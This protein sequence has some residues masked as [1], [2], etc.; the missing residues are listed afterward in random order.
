MDKGFLVLVVNV[1][2]TTFKF[3]L[4]DMKESV[5]LAKGRFERVG[6]EDSS[7]EYEGREAIIGGIL[8]TLGGYIPC[9]NMM[10]SLLIEES[11]IEAAE[12]IDAIG[13]KAVMC[14]KNTRPTVVD[15]EILSQMN[16]YS[17]VAPAHN[18]PYIA[19]MKAFREMLPEVPQVAVFDTAFHSTIPDYASVYSLRKDLCDKHDIRKYGFH[20][21]SHSYVAWKLSQVYENAS[22]IISCHLGGSASICAIKDG[23]SVDTSMGFSPQSGLPMNNRN[24]DVDAFALLYLMEK[25]DMSPKAMRELLSCECGLLG[26]SGVSGDMRDL[27]ISDKP[28]ANLAI[29]SFAYS[30]KK[31]I[32]S[33]LAVLGG[34]DIISFSGGIG[35][36]S[37][38]IRTL[39]L[40]GL[41]NFGVKLDPKKNEVRTPSELT[42]ISASDSA[43][44]VVVTPSNEELMVA[45]KTY[46]TVREKQI[47]S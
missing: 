29:K 2:S 17:F 47:S 1:G 21:A 28:E 11:V 36:N 33:Y 12:D 10:F 24:G 32:G 25:E 9:I 20:G 15:D 26:I 7:Y 4:F 41:E 22:K 14:G 37:K 43:V 30:V 3:R 16:S 23:R 34:V 31:Y 42:E 5:T 40:D 38:Y 39:A 18:P 46:D 35:E 27:E 19:A 8:N 44:K 6:E 45:K 13:F